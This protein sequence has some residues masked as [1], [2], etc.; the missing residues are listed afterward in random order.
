MPPAEDP[1]N[2]PGNRR[3]QYRLADHPL[4]AWAALGLFRR[5]SM[6]ELEQELL[7]NFF[8]STNLF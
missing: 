7:L 5:V 2:S 3:A 8:S 1:P 6:L 4:A